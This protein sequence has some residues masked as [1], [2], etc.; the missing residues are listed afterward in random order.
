MEYIG[1]IISLLALIYLFFKQTQT[2]SREEVDEEGEED[3]LSY[4]QERPMKAKKTPLPP[5]PS[6][7]KYKPVRNETITLEKYH[8]ESPI[9]K[10]RL[11]SELQTRQLQSKLRPEE[12]LAFHEEHSTAPSKLSRLLEQLPDKKNL[13]IY[14][15]I[16]GKPRALR[17]YDTL[18]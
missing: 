2:V 15:E 12:F 9:E 13:I 5:P 10:R 14:Q 18:W 1:F 3:L 17:P 6:R 11:K 7:K 8:I 16:V 4:F